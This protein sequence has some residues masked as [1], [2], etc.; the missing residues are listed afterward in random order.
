MK[1]ESCERYLADPETHAAHLEK[2]AECAAL[3]GPQDLPYEH[4]PV[5]VESLPLAPWE[6]ASHRPWALVGGGALALLVIAAALFFAAGVAPMSGIAGAIGSGLPPVEIAKVLLSHVGTAA[7]HAPAGW[8]IAVGV[9][10]VIVNTV[11][12]YLLRRA[13]KGI[14]VDA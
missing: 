9:L 7:Q 3:F 5:D 10:F 11:L 8:Q 1:S 13:P 6:G 4:K 12:F 2:C 14:D